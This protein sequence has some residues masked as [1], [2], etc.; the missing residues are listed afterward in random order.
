ML[1]DCEFSLAYGNRVLLH[2]TRLKLKRGKCYGLIGPNGAGK[3]TLMRSIAAGVV[4]GFPKEIRSV[5]VE[6]D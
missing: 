4:E 3:S 1:C 2:N 6:C 5:Y